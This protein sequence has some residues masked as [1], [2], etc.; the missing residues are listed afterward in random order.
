VSVPAVHPFHGGLVLEGHKRIST[1]H[2]VVPARLPERLVVPLQQHIG[3][4]AEPVVQVGERVLKGQPI[5]RPRGYVS[6]AVHA[7]SSGTVAAIEARPVPHPSG[8]AAPCIVIETDGEERW[9]WREDQRPDWR[10]LGP[11]ALRERVRE[12]GIVGMGGAGFPTHVK[13]NPGAGRAIHTLVINGAECEPYITCD[14]MLMREHAPAV[15]A[16][17]QVMQRI[18]GARRILIGIESDKP[19]AREALSEAVRAA[20]ADDIRVV[21]VPARYPSGGERQLIHLLTGLEVPSEGLPADIGVVCQNA[22]TAA[23]VL[24]AV[25]ELEPLISRIVTVTGAGVAEPRNLEVLVGTPFADV[26]DQAGGYTD[27]AVRLIVGGPMMGFAVAHD[28]VPVTKTVNCLLVAGRGEVEPAR[29]PLPCIRCGACVEACPARLL[30]Q[31][32]YWYARAKDFDRV[33]DYRLFD[34]IEC[35]CCAAVCPSRI[36]LV[37]YYRYAKS[38]IWA[39][40]REREKAARARRRHEARLARLE[41]ERAEREARQR[42]RRERAT[43]AAARKA[44][45]AEAL[46]RAGARRSGSAEARR[47]EGS[48]GG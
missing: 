40:E 33:Q 39:L 11:E 26:I 28:E 30:P 12:A 34:C 43:D 31:Q 42:A 16:G 3:A 41:R 1:R 45:V 15:V 24:R 36:P 20:G 10:T 23:A 8:L 22:A 29:D 46:A 27:E 48:E 2:P 32:L 9:R 35:G 17:A 38:E 4:P 5:A 6:A 7:P 14:D 37:D 13:L 25:T 47:H 21:S 19:E 18:L 44:A